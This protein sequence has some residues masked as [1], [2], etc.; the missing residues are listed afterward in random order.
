[1]AIVVVSSKD[2]KPPYGRPCRYTPVVCGYWPV[3]IDA[4]LGQQSELVVNDSENV[5]PRSTSERWTS[6]IAHSVSH[7][8]SS[9]T[10]RRIEGRSVLL[11]HRG[12]TR[13][14]VA[15]SA[16]SGPSEQANE[17]G[18]A[19]EP[20]R[21]RSVPRPGA[22]L[23]NSLADDNRSGPGGVLRSVTIE[24]PSHGSKKGSANWTTPRSAG[25]SS[26]STRAW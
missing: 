17:R 18:R 21:G 6:G 11:G 20:H 9:V 25:S 5:M 10:I 1:M 15:T 13:L 14:S 7:R 26:A 16:A 2:L 3:R 12:W 8:W 24:D 23:R 4:R 19:C 22:R